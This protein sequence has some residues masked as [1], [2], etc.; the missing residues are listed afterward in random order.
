M[1][2]YSSPN[3]LPGKMPTG[4][5]RRP[6]RPV[7]TIKPL[8]PRPSFEENLGNEKCSSQGRED[9]NN[10][11][12][13]SE[14]VSKLARC[15]LVFTTVAGSLVMSA[16]ELRFDIPLFFIS[17]S[18]LEVLGVSSQ[19]TI[20]CCSN[21]LTRALQLPSMGSVLRS[22]ATL[23]FAT[24]MT[25]MALTTYH[26]LQRDRRHQDAFIVG[27]V[28]AGVTGGWLYELDGTS[29]LLRVAPWC[30]LLGLLMSGCSPMRQKQD[31]RTDEM[32]D[33]CWRRKLA[34]VNFGTS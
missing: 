24:A 27:A 26:Y 17:R 32:S 1:D 8:Q 14:D 31:W 2:R 15:G 28:A 25:G 23:I 4:R 12:P 34:D 10:D 21:M 18:T 16:C 9:G 3:R 5:P 29:I 7:P 30:A 19:R 33:N 20:P 6:P 11:G 22:P 13:G